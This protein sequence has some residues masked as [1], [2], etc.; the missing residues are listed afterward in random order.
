MKN[1]LRVTLTRRMLKESL[2]KLMVGK[3]LSKI[4][5]SEL[6]ASAGVNRVTFYHH[7]ESPAMILRDIAWDY[8]EELRSRYDEAR[9]QQKNEEDAL[10]E[11][12]RY[13]LEC[14]PDIKILL[15]E[16]AEN[17]VSGYSLE[18]ISHVM[19]THKQAISKHFQG[20]STDGFLYAV[21]T[22]SAA[23]G[24]IQVWLTQDVDKTPKEIAAIMKK[25][26]V[27]L[28]S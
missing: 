8:S 10:A 3:P 28:F 20:N 23:Y 2:L 4:T 11:C 24:L 25:A 21:T 15:S 7:Y 6:C 12:L 19:A 13:L 27:N 1:D 22:A 26:M 14:K 16:N 5:V 9:R 17:A 18:I